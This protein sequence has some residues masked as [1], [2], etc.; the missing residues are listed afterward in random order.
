M[1]LVFN[2][3]VLFGD[4]KNNIYGIFFG[5]FIMTN[6]CTITNMISGLFFCL[7]E[8]GAECGVEGVS[9]LHPPEKHK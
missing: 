8:C 7:L 9:Y 6:I 5:L 4:K 3:F 1:V 2:V